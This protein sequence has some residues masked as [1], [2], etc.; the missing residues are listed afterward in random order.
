MGATPDIVFGKAISIFLTILSCFQIPFFLFQIEFDDPH[1][2][3]LKYLQARE[4]LGRCGGVGV[5]NLNYLDYEDEQQVREM[6]GALP[7]ERRRRPDS[8]ARKGGEEDSLEDEVQIQI[9]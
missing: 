2:L 4:W 7:S 9:V 6:W 5:W 1:S 8:L 3:R